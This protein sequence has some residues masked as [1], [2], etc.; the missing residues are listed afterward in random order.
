[1]GYGYDYLQ[2]DAALEQLSRREAAERLRVSSQFEQDVVARVLADV[3]LQH[4]VSSRA[5]SEALA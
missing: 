2:A 1:L 3:T 4:S 5:V